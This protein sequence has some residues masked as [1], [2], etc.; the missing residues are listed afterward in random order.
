[1]RVIDS[2]TDIEKHPQPI[3]NGQPAIIGKVGQPRT[4]DVLHDEIRQTAICGP[5]VEQATDVRML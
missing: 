4:I 1:M 2:R 5:A 3:V